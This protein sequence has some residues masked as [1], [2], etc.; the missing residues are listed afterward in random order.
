MPPLISIIIPVYNVEQYLDYCIQSVLSQDY[1][2]LEI[3]LID[4]GSTDSSGQKCDE[5][6]DRD[7]RVK[8][9]HQKN[10][11]LSSARN[12]GLKEMTGEYFSFI[13]SDDYVRTDYI[14]RMYRIIDEDKS[15]MVVCSYKKVIGNEDYSVTSGCD[16]IHA[17]YD[18]EEIKLE[19]VSRKIPMYAHGKLYKKEFA[20][21]MDFPEGRLFEDILTCW[22]VI[23]QVEKV[24][25]SDVKI[26]F[27][28]QRIDSIVNAEFKHHRM[29]Q[30]FFSK[31]IFEETP[32]NTSL[33]NAAGTRCFFAAADD[34]ALLTKGY[35]KEKEYLL[36]SIRMFRTYVLKDSSAELSIKLMALISYL[37]PGIV[38]VLG[39]LYK[40]RNLKKWLRETAK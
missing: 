26:Y 39:R 15:D 27:Y 36:K 19:M 12:T 24:S 17:V 20:E 28:R 38:R 5:Y 33:R 7:Q 29:D 4:D 35:P 3:I 31:R 30:V 14:S 9:I 8:V 2:N 6:A 23:K 34:Y 16:N 25:Y 32:E 1:T 22:N 10:G 37:C 21:Y 13:D 40:R 11:G 18:K